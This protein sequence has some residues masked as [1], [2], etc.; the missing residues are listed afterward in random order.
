M[1][2]SLPPY[3][4]SVHWKDYEIATP[5]FDLTPVE[6]PDM[7]PYLVHLTGRNAIA[8]ILRCE[9]RP[10]GSKNG[11]GFLKAQIPT[12]SL[13]NYH[14][15]VVCFTESPTFALDFFRYRVFRRWRDDFRYGIGLSKSG[16]V[17]RGVRPALYLPEPLTKLLVQ[18]H[19]LLGQHHFEDE[20][21]EQSL[22]EFFE[23]V[24]P[25]S[26]PLLESQDAQGFAWER[27]WRFTVPPGLEFDHSD[28]K[29]ICCPDEER[30]AIAAI[31]GKRSNDVVFVRSWIEFSIVRDFFS[32][33]LH[34]WDAS[35]TPAL[36]ADEYGK[37]LQQKT[38]ALHWLEAYLN[39]L[40]HAK[41]EFREGVAFL[42]TLR[43]EI[44]TLEERLKQFQ[45]SSL[46]LPD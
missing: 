30:N 42:A 11:F 44:S 20:S 12:Q 34:A 8:S 18:L 31:L 23:M 38:A 26:T 19:S 16:M 7:S 14:A 35:P 27:E 39:T 41:T 24:Y 36:T 5:T 33:K 4:S 3:D 13:G 22:R 17:E 37:L 45:S 25:L 40:V 46:E 29:V 6:K 32:R 10:E 9:G 1:F 21:C 15:E 43:S 2:K 28:I